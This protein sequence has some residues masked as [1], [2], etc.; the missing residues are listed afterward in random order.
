MER[1]TLIHSSEYKYRVNKLLKSIAY[2]TPRPLRIA[3]IGGGQSAA[4]VTINLHNLLGDIPAGDGPVGHRV[5]MII[6]K[7]SLKP[8]DDTQFSNEIFDPEGDLN[9]SSFIWV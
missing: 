1:S 3:V 5:D 9:R 7:G 4:E 8:S 2:T 6:R